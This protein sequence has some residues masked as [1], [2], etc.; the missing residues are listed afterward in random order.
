MRI[1]IRNTDHSLMVFISTALPSHLRQ[2][3]E[4]KLTACMA[5][6]MQL[7]TMD[8]STA[9]CKGQF[10]AIHFSWYNRHCT[11]VCMLTFNVYVLNQ[12]DIYRRATMLPMMFNPTT[13]KGRMELALTITR[14]F[15]ICHERPWII[16]KTSNHYIGSFQMYLV[17]CVRRYVH[18]PGVMRVI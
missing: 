7:E 17:T 13:C 15:H 4:A 16:G 9:L 10:T 12:T 14:S 3:L 18:Y 11:P 6:I 1:D 2:A 8:S 5:G